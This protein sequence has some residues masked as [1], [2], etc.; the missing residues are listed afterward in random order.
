MCWSQEGE[1][2]IKN[3]VSSGLEDKMCPVILILKKTR[4]IYVISMN[5]EKNTGSYL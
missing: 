5:L 2:I 4:K 1:S 3:R